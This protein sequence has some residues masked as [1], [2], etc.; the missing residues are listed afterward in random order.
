MWFQTAGDGG[1]LIRRGLTP[2]PGFLIGVWYGHIKAIIG[3]FNSGGGQDTLIEIT[4]DKLYNDNTWHHVTF[5]RDR[6]VHKL[7][8]YIDDEPSTLPVEDNFSLPLISDR[9][10]TM[11]R[12]E[13]PYYPGYFTGSLDEVKIT[14]AAVHPASANAPVI[15]VRPQSWNFGKTLVGSTSLKNVEISNAGLHDTLVISNI[16]STNGIFLPS[17]NSMELRPGEVRHLDLLYAPVSVHQDT[18]TILISS[19][20]SHHATISVPVSGEG[21][22][23]SREPIIAGIQD[24]PHDQGGQVRVIWS[25]SIYDGT[26]DSLTATEYNLW[27]RVDP[28]FAAAV[29]NAHHNGTIFEVS[30]R[31]LAFVNSELWDYIARIPAVQFHSYAYVAPTTADST[32]AGGIHW[33]TFEVSAHMKT[34][35]FYFSQPDSG[36]STDGTPPAAPSNVVVHRAPGSADVN[37]EAS[38]DP[39]IDHYEVYGGTVH[40]FIADQTSIIG[41]T[42]TNEF[43][44]EGAAASVTTYYRVKAFD[45]AGNQS[46]LSNEAG[47]GITSVGDRRDIP[48]EFRLFQ[49]YPNPF[50]PSSTL[51]YD[52]ASESNVIIRIYNITGQEIATIVNE[53]KKPGTYHVTWNAENR[54]TGIYFVKMTA[55]EF[56]SLV[57]MILI[58]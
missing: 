28:D 41:R 51:K 1:H 26:N 7:F 48:S 5:V 16:T 49:N 19:N 44:D 46:S 10:L 45:K 38:A 52:V 55:G 47:G 23:P 25:A 57:K 29:K 15:V 31:K 22:E 54:P 33:T 12:W 14:K 8:L 13:N 32:A 40:N 36:Y 56:T 27:R 30:G 43:V 20:D 35:E 3:D 11:G 50:N 42:L 53:R 34:G 37:W 18:A 2:A 39:D 6:S 17:T 4:S 58:K 21:Y 9:P 24:I